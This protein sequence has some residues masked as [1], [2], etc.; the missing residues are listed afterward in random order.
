MTSR[1]RTG[2][3][4]RV[5]TRGRGRGSVKQGEGLNMRAVCAP[6]LTLA[7]TETT[8][9]VTPSFGA[10]PGS[11]LRALRPLPFSKTVDGTR[12]PHQPPGWWGLRYLAGTSGGG[13]GSAHGIV[14][15]NA[16]TVSAMSRWPRRDGWISQAPSTLAMSPLAHGSAPR[17]GVTGQPGGGG[18]SVRAPSQGRHDAWPPRHGRVSGASIQAFQGVGDHVSGTGT[19]AH[20]GAS[21]RARVQPRS[22]GRHRKATPKASRSAPATPFR[23]RAARS[24]RA[25]RRS[26]TAKTATMIASGTT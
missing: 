24:D 9:T 3:P 7:T 18:A 2:P 5:P 15:R 16:S 1:R 20:Q 12:K 13:R 25:S 23:T 22:P 11:L 8:A 26:V 17:Q 21:T 14:A 4:R 10:P 6:G 19:R